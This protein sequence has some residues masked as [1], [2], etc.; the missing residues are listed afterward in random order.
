MSTNAG[1]YGPWTVL[2]G[3]LA[4]LPGRTVRVNEAGTETLATLYT[5]KTRTAEAANP[6]TVDAL[7]NVTFFADPGDY[8]MLLITNGVLGTPVGARVFED[9]LE[10]EAE[11]AEGEEFGGIPLNYVNA[12]DTAYGFAEAATGLANRA[13]LQ[14]AAT[15]AIAADKDLFIPPGAF[16]V[17]VD[18]V[19]IA[20]L[21]SAALRVFGKGS[22]K[23]DITVTPATATYTQ[24]LFDL[25]GTTG[26]YTVE[27]MT[28]HGPTASAAPVGHAV[29]WIAGQTV[30]SNLVCRDLVVDGQ[31]WDS[32]ISQSG[33]ADVLLDG[34]DL[35][36]YEAGIKMF[37][38]SDTVST[39]LT[40]KR[41]RIHDCPK[42][43]NS[44]GV[45]VHPHIQL[46]VDSDCVFENLHR[47]GVY[48]NGSPTMAN[49]HTVIRGRY[50]NCGVAQTT[51]NGHARVVDFV[52]EGA[53]L[54]A[55]ASFLIRKDATVSGHFKGGTLAMSSLG[56]SEQHIVLD[57]VTGE[58]LTSNLINTA[59]NPTYWRM[60]NCDIELA[61]GRVINQTG[62]APYLEVDG[63]TVRGTTSQAFN[64]STGKTRL[65]NIVSYLTGTGKVF[66]FT[67]GT[68]HEVTGFRNQGTST[69]EV[70]DATSMAAGTVTG[71]DNDFTGGTAGSINAANN[72]QC[73][74][75][76]VGLAPTPV[77]SAATLGLGTGGTAEVNSHDSFVVTGNTTINTIS[78]PTFFIG[79]I[80]LIAAAGSAWGLG[81][82]GNIVAAAGARAVNSVVTLFWEP[83][84][85]KWLEV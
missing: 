74:T 29:Y 43:S 70:L 46:D 53:S 57:G 51:S 77:A 5:D 58:A 56:A 76:R 12:G 3:N 34:C 44:I 31:G 30:G 25:T 65:R 41:T 24:F 63:V 32:P 78:G 2:T 42:P 67:G 71:R 72:Q 17:E 48:Q 85:A 55:V 37:E 68:D 21:L 36:G 4:L 9:P 38:S 11:E 66:N 28:V 8:D 45:Y 62:T 52:N 15:A 49:P 19:N 18:S 33:K 64:I 61:G 73:V 79:T 35:S 59:G 40:L 10:E 81:A 14:A 22:D 84:A 50:V 83:T 82:A 39:K 80:R 7:G 26:T 54:S 13:A 75:R 20:I 60:Q 23:T 47:W 69:G 16:T 6:V 27:G 1:K